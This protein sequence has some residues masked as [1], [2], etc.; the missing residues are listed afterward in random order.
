MVQTRSGRRT[1]VAKSRI[2]TPVGQKKTRI[3]KFAANSESLAES[4]C[5]DEEKHAVQAELHP[6]LTQPAE[7]G[8]NDQCSKSIVVENEAGTEKEILT[9]TGTSEIC[10]GNIE[11]N[12]EKQ[13]LQIESQPRSIRLKLFGDALE[14]AD[15]KSSGAE[16][17]ELIETRKTGTKQDKERDNHENKG[18]DLDCKIISNSSTGITFLLSSDEDKCPLSSSISDVL[19]G[20]RGND[21]AEDSTIPS[22]PAGSPLAKGSDLFVIDTQPGIDQGRTFYLD[23]S[24]RGD[25][26]ESGAET[27]VGG[28]ESDQEE[29]DEFIDEEDDILKS[30]SRLINSSSSIDTGLNLKELGGLYISFN[31][32]KPAQATGSKDLKKQKSQREDTELLANSIL[33][34]EYEKQHSIPA[35]KVSER[36]LKKM[37]KKERA[38]TTGDSWYN[39]KAPDLTEELKNDLQVLKMRSAIDPKRFYKR[40]DRV[41][42]P[43][44]FQVGEV[45]NN[46]V[47]FYHS[48]LPKKQRKRTMVEELLADA[49]F[50]RYNKKRYQQIMAEKATLARRKNRKKKVKK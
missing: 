32:N 30:K 4:Y 36:Q 17:E 19:E 2:R 42:F 11:I 40:N 13:I 44:Y 48:R 37:R 27:R 15:L 33:T 23:T 1:V 22:V 50:R 5:E 45:L 49:Q 31:V 7:L 9:A 25:G 34:P 47:D 28:D 24:G 10:I 20:S 6:S 12:E 16:K 21:I 41:G 43:K 38:K 46:P 18:G 26:E 39:M 8:L 29:E 35:L 3:S 14:L